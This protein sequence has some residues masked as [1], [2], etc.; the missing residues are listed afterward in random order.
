VTPAGKFAGNLRG[1]YSHKTGRHLDPDGHNWVVSYAHTYLY[2][3]REQ[4]AN[5]IVAA[6]NWSSMWLNQKQ[7]FAHLRTPFWYELNDNWADR[8][9]IELHKGRND[10]LVKVGK[11]KGTPG[12][13]YGFTFRVADDKDATLLRLWPAHG[14]VRRTNLLTPAIACVGPVG[15]GL[16]SIST[17]MEGDGPPEPD[18]L[19]VCQFHY[20]RTRGNSSRVGQIGRRRIRLEVVC[21]SGEAVE[22]NEALGRHGAREIVVFEHPGVG[23]MHVDGVKTGG[24]RGVD[25]GTGAVTDHPCGLGCERVACDDLAIGVGV[26]LGRDFDRGEVHVDAGAIELLLLLER[27]SL[28]DEDEAMTLRQEGERLGDSGE[29]LDGLIGDGP[30]EARDALPLLVGGRG[31]GELCKAVEQGTLEAGHSISV[32]CNRCVFTTV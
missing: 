7:V 23:V 5:F 3:P 29:Q 27:I 30:R 20:F 1:H 17:G 25:I 6:D 10:V 4:H 32:R 12:G 24:E 2:S 26:L 16:P 15:K 11:G 28:G 9:P 21:Q 18:V 13:F 8:V 14:L 31:L 19:C 22:L